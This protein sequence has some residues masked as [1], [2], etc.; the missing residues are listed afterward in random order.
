[1]ANTDKQQQVTPTMEET[2]NTSEAFFLKYKKAIIGV[3]VAVIVIIAGAVLYKTYVSEPNEQKASTAIAKGQ[4]YFAQG[5]FQ[6]ALDGDSTGFKGFVK[7]ADE[8]SSTDAG[9]LV[10][11]YAG[12]CNA[13]LDKWDAAVKYLE[14]YDGADDQM[15]SPVAEGA[16]GNAYA[17]LNQLDKAVSHLKKA[18]DK[19]DNNS[20]SPTFLIQAG[21][22]L[23][24]QG[25]ASEALKLYQQVK[26]KYFN[27]MQ[28]QRID[29][30]I[31]RVSA[32]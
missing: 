25:K 3:V 30:Y 31:E 7:L 19:A 15:I 10:N 9:N 13:Q 4:E 22:I 1:M 32:K 5:L 17:H 23:E 26:E 14:K 8:Y 16:L 20:L 18:A 28:Y 24:S 6:Q 21:E 2:L 12:L 11:L 27:S 29:E